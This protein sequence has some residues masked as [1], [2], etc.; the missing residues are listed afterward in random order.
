MEGKDYSRILPCLNGIL[1]S[2][3]DLYPPWIIS[4]KNSDRESWKC[5][6][7]CRSI[8]KREATKL[9]GTI[10]DG[11]GTGGGAYEYVWKV[12][13]QLPSLSRN[14]ICSRYNRVLP[15]AGAVAAIGPIG[16]ATIRVSWTRPRTRFCSK[17]I[18]FERHRVEAVADSVF[19]TLPDSF[20]KSASPIRSALVAPNLPPPSSSP[21][22][23]GFGL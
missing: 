13:R 19:I 1:S 23:K 21:A 10:F 5:W 6:K 3:T 9:I 2:S 18:F 22:W 16:M 15:V 20:A 17:W 11:I 12:Y 4:W 7:S 14:D 8:D